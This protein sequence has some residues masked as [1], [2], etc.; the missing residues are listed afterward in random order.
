M[1]ANHCPEITPEE[2]IHI[3]TLCRDA[4]NGWAN[5]DPL[6]EM[7]KLAHTVLAMRP[8]ASA[9]TSPQAYSPL[10]PPDS[11]LY[12]GGVKTAHWYERSMYAYVD[13]DR[14]KRHTHAAPLS[15]HE[16][17]E[18]F[19]EARNGSNKPVGTLRGIKAVLA[20]ASIAQPEKEPQERKG[21][22]GDFWGWIRSAHRNPEAKSF[23]LSDMAVA[24]RAGSDSSG[25]IKEATPVD[26]KFDTEDPM[27]EL[28]A[29][30]EIYQTTFNRLPDAYMRK[31]V[32][33]V[34]EMLMTWFG[35]HRE[36]ITK[37]MRES[38]AEPTREDLLHS[39][40]FMLGECESKADETDDRLLKH[41]V[42]GYYRQWNKANGDDKQ[43]R[44]KR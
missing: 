18:A 25:Q 31:T 3:D 10:P 6:G 27:A 12:V 34:K 16:L 23:T 5:G 28:E 9:C 35:G 4:F 11:E 7:K 14:A 43:P 24:Y 15:D 1:M 39:F 26:W 36:T 38:V 8:P 32:Q 30:L 19:E 44:W 21:Q 29:I 33:K 37:A 2:A 22:K 13:A 41:L 17:Y 42:E 20:L 40:W